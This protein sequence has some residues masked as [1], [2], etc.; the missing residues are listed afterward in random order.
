MRISQEEKE[1]LSPNDPLQD[2]M[3]ILKDMKQR[4]YLSLCA[5]IARNLEYK[6]KTAE[7]AEFLDHPDDIKILQ[8]DVEFFDS[9]VKH[10]EVLRDIVSDSMWAIKGG[11]DGRIEKALDMSFRCSQYDGSHHK[12][13]CNDQMVR[14]LTGCPMVEKK[15]ID[16]RGKEY[17][18]ETQGESD[19]YL[20]WIEKYT[21]GGQYE[22]NTGTPA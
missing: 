9:R 3:F 19:D 5:E 8:K 10:F 17:T 6:V 16:C 20:A 7:A 1:R 4:L 2:A 14:A 22:W 15:A 18:Y 13:W 21:E 12:D 11:F